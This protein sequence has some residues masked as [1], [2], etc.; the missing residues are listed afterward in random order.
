MRIIELIG[1]AYLLALLHDTERAEGEETYR[2][3]Q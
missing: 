2:E 3:N 1:S